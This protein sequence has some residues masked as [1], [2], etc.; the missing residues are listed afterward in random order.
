MGRLAVLVA[1]VALAVASPA[2]AFSSGVRLS[3]ARVFNPA[4]ESFISFGTVPRAPLTVG[5]GLFYVA[6]TA[7]A[8]GTP[9]VAVPQVESAQLRI[10]ELAP[11]AASF[12][13]SADLSAIALAQP[14]IGG[15]AASVAP[16]ASPAQL[17]SA[18]P[19]VRFGGYANYAPPLDDGVAAP[20]PVRIGRLEFHGSVAASSQPAAANAFRDMQLCGTTDAAAP[21]EA[22]G[23]V[24]ALK[25]S[26]GT[27]LAVRTGGSHVD[28]Q[29]TGSISNLNDAAAA[30]FPY[31]PLNPDAEPAVPQL[32]AT[33]DAPM[34]YYPGLTA[35][36]KQDVAAGIAVPVTQRLTLGLQYD[37]QR[38]QGDYGSTAL[39]SLDAYKDTYLGKL[40][41]RLPY[42]N[43][44][45][46][47]SARQ[48]RYQDTFSPNFNLTQTRADLNFTVKF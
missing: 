20:A 16:G 33:A 34:L 41:Y 31:V 21:C 35:L 38:Y 6:Q 22:R 39:P 46:T 25:L 19:P 12:E 48:N 2:A 37:R 28:L 4:A 5:G 30:V 43:S 18:P 10:A 11:Q 14:A 42:A 1:A 24:N 29:L 36:V 45:I 40:T 3:Q 15:I 27:D 8:L 47:L 17:P 13:P 7:P 9:G 32:N 26:A 44:A 23:G